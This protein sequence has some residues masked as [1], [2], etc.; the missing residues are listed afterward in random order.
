MPRAVA[1]S[2]AAAG[3]RICDAACAA[4]AV[5][6]LCCHAVVAAGGS[7]QHVLALFGAIGLVA[8]AVVLPAARR[9]R[10]AAPTGA[11][12]APPP[13]RPWRGVRAAG[14]A[15]GLAGVLGFALHENALALW[16][17]G[18][19]SLALGAGAFLLAEPARVEA[20]AAS[21][22]LELGLFG[23]GLL[24]AAIT[25]LIHR[26]D[27][28]DA[29][30]V[31]LAVAAADAPTAPLLVGDTLHGI[32]NLS[33][34]LPVY[35]LHSYELLNG[36]LAYLSGIPAIYVFHWIAAPLGALFLAL[37]HARLFRRLTPRAWL[38]GVAAVAVVVLV[39]G[40]THRWHGNFAL[41]RMWQGKS[42]LLFVLMPLVYSYAIEFG[43]RPS[44]RGWLLLAAAQIGAVGAS[45]TALW[46]A[47]A[48]ALA[49]MA[50]VV[51]PTR[52]DLRVF[53]VGALA[54]LYVLGAGLALKPEMAK[55]GSSASAQPAATADRLDEALATTLGD[56]RL[57]G[58]ALASVL[59]GW[60]LWGPGLA[61]RFA[62][63]V[64]LAAWLVLL[65]PYW[66]GWVRANVTGSSY[67]RA[68][69]ALPVPVL[70]SLVL[71]SPLA[72]G[73][74]RGRRRLGAL[75][76]A[77]LT[78]G[79]AVAVPRYA[80]VSERNTGGGTGIRLGWPP[81]LKVPEEEYRWA[82]ALH[83]SVP[84]GST[85]V[86]PPDVSVWLPT[87]QHPVYPVM[88]RGSYLEVYVDQL[89][90]AELRRRAVVTRYSEGLASGPR[91]SLI[92]R[93]GLERWNVRGVCIRN[94]EYASEA[95]GILRDL[96]F[97]R[98]LQSTDR[99]IWVRP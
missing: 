6:T 8:A 85:V 37:A 99:E 63:A 89:G 39:V 84:A 55:P 4:F 92:F 81:A 17:C 24:L 20:P 47:P 51:R 28:D 74:G 26:P 82:V 5:W 69:W 70:I 18:V 58:F 53:A 87:F 32:P 29:F 44:A 3:D 48:S 83:E 68:M 2:T 10:P 91:A 61:R 35:R 21:R 65:S 54:S 97:R 98:T 50:A 12:P 62:V 86:A 73:A 30:Y 19:G 60:A 72:S 1:G 66:D 33:L 88:V 46:A 59:A 93:E 75:A 96:G 34:H 27:I 45:S 79:F 77:A 11:P 31:N 95:R 14:L 43:L 57:R 13:G 22:R 76:S 16:W 9:R 94:S 80:A 7:L 38:A 36:A 64:P 25:F 71:I 40:E 42:I 41:V 23:L 49:G 67:W 90:I 78:L 15:L 52:R 56:G